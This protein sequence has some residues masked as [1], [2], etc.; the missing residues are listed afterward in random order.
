MDEGRFAP[1]RRIDGMRDMANELNGRRVAILATD[2]VERVELEQPRQA[3]DTA[4]CERILQEFAVRS[5]GYG[6]RSPMT[7]PTPRLPGRP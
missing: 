4:F 5:L 2:G 3:L 6:L 7:G 1:K